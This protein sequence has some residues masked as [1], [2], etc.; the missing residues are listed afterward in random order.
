MESLHRGKLDLR[1]RRGGGTVTVTIVGELDI[2]TVAS[3]RQCLFDVLGGET[4]VHDD[5]PGGEAGVHDA[6]PGGEAGVPGRGPAR[7]EVLGGGPERDESVER[8][9]VELSGLSFIDAAGL[10]TLV[11]VHNRARRQAIPLL[12]AGVSP[13]TNRL[14]K[15]TGLDACFT[16]WADRGDP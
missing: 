2:A 12:L 11:A 14:L 10:G 8:V 16:R 7:D 3:L 1:T 9:V 15:I 4:E 13:N 5:V 6:V